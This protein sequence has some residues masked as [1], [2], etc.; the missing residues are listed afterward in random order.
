MVRTP[1]VPVTISE[2]DFTKKEIFI[3]EGF[4]YFV[5]IK[6]KP[7]GKQTNTGSAE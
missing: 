6:P 2:T 5:F 4:V 7:Y 1:P 3:I